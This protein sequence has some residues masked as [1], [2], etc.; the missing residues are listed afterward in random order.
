MAIDDDRARKM[1]EEMMQN[2]KTNWGEIEKKVRE[3]SPLRLYLADKRSRPARTPCEQ[4][5]ARLA[6][7]RVV[8][9]PVAWRLLPGQ[10]PARERVSRRVEQ[11]AE[12]GTGV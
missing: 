2:R 9:R 3:A 10:S 1:W 7:C 5:R 4:I 6:K 12:K 8:F 11:F